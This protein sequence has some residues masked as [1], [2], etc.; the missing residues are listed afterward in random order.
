M[1]RKGA[2]KESLEWDGR[3][4]FFFFHTLLLSLGGAEDSECCIDLGDKLM[5][6]RWNGSP[7]LQM[8][9]ACEWE[10]DMHHHKHGLACC[11]IWLLEKQIATAVAASPLKS[12]YET[13]DHV[14]G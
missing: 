11:N 12:M 14:E 1:A 7:G 13:D 6:V 5:G 4:F 3:F 8:P 10:V 9:P 2:R